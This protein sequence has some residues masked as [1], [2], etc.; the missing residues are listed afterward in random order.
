M[1]ASAPIS[2]TMSSASLPIAM[3]SP[4]PQLNSSPI[5]ADAGA[6]PSVMN[7]SAVSST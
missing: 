4:G 3:S 7:A 1:S 2:R 5:T 6:L